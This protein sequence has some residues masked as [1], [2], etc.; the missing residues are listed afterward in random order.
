MAPAHAE[1]FTQSIPIA[2]SSG[3]RADGEA[4]GV[5][6]NSSPGVATHR[7]RIVYDFRR[8]VLAERVRAFVGAYNA[9]FDDTRIRRAV[10]RPFCCRWLYFDRLLNARVYGFP[11]FFP[12]PET[13][14]TLIRLKTGTESPAYALAIES[15]ADSMTPGDSQCF[16]FYV[17]DEDGSNRRENMTDW[18]LDRFRSHYKDPVISKWSIFDYVYAVLHHPGYRK[19][20][21]DHLKRELPRIP[22]APD[23]RAFQQAGQ[24]LIRLHLDYE[25]LEPWPLEFE[26]TPGVPLSYRVEDKMRLSKD[27]ARLT[28]N[29]SLALAGIPPEAFEY[30]L[31]NRSALEWVIDQYQVSTDKRSGITS[32]P[33]REEDPQYIVRLVGQ[34]IRVGVETMKVV[35]ALPAEFAGA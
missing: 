16:P 18:A 35:N 22:F 3:G 32:D 28:V 13:R 23:F 10:Y 30:R 6:K 4:L 1:E 8:E 34:V 7:D 29:P 15:I 12:T 17:Y 20:F 5:F 31:G 19:K 21:A 24:A 2:T 14:N 25:K 9:E 27:K 33:N 11:G 26:Q